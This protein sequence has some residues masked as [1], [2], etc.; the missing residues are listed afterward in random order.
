MI[1]KSE[2]GD[3]VVQSLMSHVADL[4]HPAALCSSYE[5]LIP[6]SSLYSNSLQ[7]FHAHILRIYT[8]VFNN[9][10]RLPLTFTDGTQ[11]RMIHTCYDKLTDGSA[12]KLAERLWD[13]TIR[14][15]G[16]LYERRKREEQDRGRGGGAGGGGPVGGLG[17]P[18]GLPPL[19]PP[20]G[21]TPM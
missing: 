8:P 15:V 10:A 14:V 4:T 16:T 3:W 6:L 17:G 13:S 9:L 21:A 18:G 5:K 7:R 2:L 12:F 11:T 1:T 20:G 19:P